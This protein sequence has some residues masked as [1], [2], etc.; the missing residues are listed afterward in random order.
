MKTLKQIEHLEGVKVLVRADFNVPVRSGVVVDDYRIQTALP[1]L[2]YL[3]SRGAKVIL[4][5]HLEKAE[6]QKHV[7]DEGVPSLRPVA[8]H[9]NKL[10][11]SVDFVEN[12]KEAHE[13]IENKLP[14]GGAILL[15]NL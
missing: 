14:N 5:S 6:G 8:E 2:N 13:I 10:G 7:T 15:E 1:T 9:L 4:I 11:T 3:L 12:Y